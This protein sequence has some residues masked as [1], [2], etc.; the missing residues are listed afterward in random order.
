M[1]EA[2]LTP[3]WGSI[4]PTVLLPD[5]MQDEKEGSGVT[6]DWRGCRGLY[7]QPVPS[8]EAK[9]QLPASLCHHPQTPCSPATGEGGTFSLAWPQG[10]RPQPGP[11][12]SH[13][14]G[15]APAKAP[16]RVSPPADKCPAPRAASTLEVTLQ[17]RDRPCRERQ[18]PVTSWDQRG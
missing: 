1:L 16:H 11:T 5:R 4:W 9:L 3:G 17:V 13:W 10:P 14:V 7:C 6:E 12:R 15:R 18:Q 2:G 8:C